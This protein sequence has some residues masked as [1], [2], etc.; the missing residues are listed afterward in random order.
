MK[1]NSVV[2][3]V[4]YFIL[5]VVIQNSVL[6]ILKDFVLVV[7]KRKQRS[8]CSQ[9]FSFKSSGVKSVASVVNDFILIV[10]K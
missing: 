2:T 4:R 3:V 6:S 9:R 1:K 7:V 8:D 5:M 10:V